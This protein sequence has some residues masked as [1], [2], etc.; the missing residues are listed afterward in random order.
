[1][2]EDLP[3]SQS[4]SAKARRSVEKHSV[5]ELRTVGDRY[6]RDSEI[7]NVCANMRVLPIF[8]RIKADGS[9]QIADQLHLVWQREVRTVKNKAFL[10]IATLLVLLFSGCGLLLTAKGLDMRGTWLGEAIIEDNGGGGPIGFYITTQQNAQFSGSFIT[11]FEEAAP[12]ADFEP[13]MKGFG[14]E[15]TGSVDLE[16]NVEM[17]V[18]EKFLIGDPDDPTFWIWE[19]AGTVEGDQMEGT[20]YQA[21]VDAD[22]QVID[23]ED[24]SGTWTAARE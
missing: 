14:F 2:E 24:F 10:V 21:W 12:L 20:F 8:S 4:G 7:S 6:G 22:D 19:F 11:F 3:D 16:G 23:D 1:M 5:I 15:M 13:A 17:N 18:R 9:K